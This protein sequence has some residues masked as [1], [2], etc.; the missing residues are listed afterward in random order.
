M[1]NISEQELLG[2]VS[3]VSK[4]CLGRCY[5]SVLGQIPKVCQEHGLRTD[6]VKRT[7]TGNLQSCSN[8]DYNSIKKD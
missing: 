8:V 6:R 5:G 4:D 1:K 7:P 2:K 3:R